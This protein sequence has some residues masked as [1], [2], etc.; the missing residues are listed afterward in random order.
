MRINGTNLYVIVAIGI[1]QSL[2]VQDVLQ[3][4]LK[5]IQKLDKLSYYY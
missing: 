3:S 1:K 5:G 4:L 2:L